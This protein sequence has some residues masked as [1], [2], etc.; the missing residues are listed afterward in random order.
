[1]SKYSI[2]KRKKLGYGGNMY[3]PNEITAGQNANTTTN[4]VHEE[5]NPEL[6]AQRIKAMEEKRAQVVAQSA[7]DTKNMETRKLNDVTSVNNEKAQD[8]ATYNSIEAGISTGLQLLP[9]AGGS[10][11]GTTAGSL[12]S[13]SVNTGVVTGRA[14]RLMKRGT[15]LATSGNARKMTR[16]AKLIN[17]SQKATTIGKQATTAGKIGSSIGT[18]ASSANGIG[19]I[20]ALAGKGISK[21]SDDKDATKWNAGEVSGDM[22]SAV[23]QG[24][25]WG[26]MLGPVGTAVGAVGGAIYGTVKGLT[27]RNKA[28]RSKMEFDDKR[29]KDARKINN[30]TMRSYGAHAG[31]SRAGELK[32]KTYSGYDYGRNTVAKYGGLKKHI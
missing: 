28:R 13:S 23:G 2:N 17:K 12:A 31:A 20:A 26:S 14:A 3:T 1:M 8:D 30:E 21:L 10:T 4:I 15:R 27:Q 9:A 19:T 11:A 18:W 5:S 7:V 29:D 22:L 16:G 6:Q 24:A 32:S 25:A